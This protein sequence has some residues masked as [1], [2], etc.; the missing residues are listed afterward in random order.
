MTRLRGC[1]PVDVGS[2]RRAAVADV[3]WTSCPVIGAGGRSRQLHEVDGLGMFAVVMDKG[4]DA[5]RELE[6]FA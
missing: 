6:R 4:D 3:D 5:A 2:R 1:R